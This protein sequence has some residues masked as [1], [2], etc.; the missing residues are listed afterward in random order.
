MLRMERKLFL[1]SGVFCKLAADRK[2]FAGF[3]C[4]LKLIGA[5]GA[6]F[7]ENVGRS[8]SGDWL[9]RIRT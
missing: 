8:P 2:C 1:R 3:E 4:S 5:G 6:T 9:V 7:Y